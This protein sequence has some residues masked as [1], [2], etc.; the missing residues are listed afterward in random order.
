[1]NNYDVIVV[2]AGPAGIFLCHELKKINPKKRVLFVEL[3][4]EIETKKL[5]EGEEAFVRRLEPVCKGLDNICDEKAYKYLGGEKFN[6]IAKNIQLTYALYANS[7]EKID[8]TDG[9]VK[10][11]E[12]LAAKYGL[13]MEYEKVDTITPLQ[14]RQLFESVKERF[15][16]LGVDKIYGDIICNPIIEDNKVLG[17]SISSLQNENETTKYYAPN[18][19]LAVGINCKEWLKNI[20]ETYNIPMASG[21]VEIGVRYEFSG[22]VLDSRY[23]KYDIKFTSPGKKEKTNNVMTSPIV[24]NGKVDVEED[25]EFAGNVVTGKSKLLNNTINFSKNNNMAIRCVYK[26]YDYDGCNKTDK[27]MCIKQRLKSESENGVIVQRLGDVMASLLK[28]MYIPTEKKWLDKNTITPS[29]KLAAPGDLIYAI[30]ETNVKEIVNM[31]MAIDNL[32]PGFACSD[33]LLYAPDIILHPERVSVSEKFETNISGLYCVG[34]LAQILS[35]GIISSSVLA[36]CLAHILSEE[37]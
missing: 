22:D 16:Y 33:S 6:Q 1:M 20:C 21:Q 18:V 29:F 11:C 9:F 27:I 19:V 4:E 31:I 28:N 23:S 8:L 3:G 2:G 12:E 32:F 26:T 14:L 30:G 17:V 10:N 37:N 24:R 36:A 35:P 7:K 34:D 25:Q 15:G 13:T 5:K